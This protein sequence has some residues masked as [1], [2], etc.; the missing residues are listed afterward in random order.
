MKWVTRERPKIDRIA[1]PWLIARFIDREPE[2]LFVAPA[3]VLE[4]ASRTGAV[5]YDAPGAELTHVGEEHSR[6]LQPPPQARQQ[7]R[8]EERK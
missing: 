3:R 7:E 8:P 6:L 4:V 1:C 5:P 2:F